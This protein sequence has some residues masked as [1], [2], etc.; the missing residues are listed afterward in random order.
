MKIRHIVTVALAAFVA[1]VI[2]MIA[3]IRAL[4]DGQ[5]IG[6]SI[7]F[8]GTVFCVYGA[9]LEKFDARRRGEYVARA[10]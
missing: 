5:V 4:T 1:A 8:A 6:F 3:D 2:S 7:L 10:N 9:M